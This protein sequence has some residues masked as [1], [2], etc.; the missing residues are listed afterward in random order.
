MDERARGIEERRRKHWEE[1]FKKKDS[2]S[3]LKFFDIMRS[4]GLYNIDK[5]V[6]EENIDRYTELFD[7][8]ILR[9]DIIL[10]NED[11]Y[12][13]ERTDCDFARLFK[14]GRVK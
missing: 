3:Y 8:A 1:V 14:I 6:V 5:I 13:K 7:E 9:E 10:D 2:E 12:I 4:Y 11:F